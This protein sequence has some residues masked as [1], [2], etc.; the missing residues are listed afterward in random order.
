MMAVQTYAPEASPFKTVYVDITHRCQMNC[1]NCYLPNRTIPDMDLNLF[2]DL[3]S[4]LPF[5]T[6]LRLVGGEPTLREDLPEIIKTLRRMGHRP[7]LITN[8]LR[9]A[10]FEY[11]K[12]LRDAGL[13][14]CQLSMNGFRDDKI[15]LAIDKMA[16][17][18]KKN[19]ALENCQT[20]GIQA[21]VSCIL[22]RGVNEHLVDEILTAAQSLN[23]PAR[24]N[25]RNVGSIGRNTS[26][27]IAPMSMQEI[28]QLVAQSLEISVDKIL[29]SK[30]A[31]NQIRFLSLPGVRYSQQIVVKITDWTIFQTS[32]LQDPKSLQRGRVTQDFRLAPHF[33]HVKEN[34]FGY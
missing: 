16:C 6:D 29:S 33:D 8:G 12:S 22:M 7:V 2:Y 9:L 19:H 5:K 20:L 32:P 11:A 15:Y 25:F 34:E 24:I 18:Q 14:Y 23:K 17:A 21:S 3:A 28:V 27:K 4:K 31:A 10:N 30:V 1:A 13:E 26:Q